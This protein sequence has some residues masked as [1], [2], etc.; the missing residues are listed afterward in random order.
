MGTDKADSRWGVAAWVMALL[1]VMAP[2]AL[3]QTP[4]RILILSDTRDHDKV[5]ETVS[6]VIDRP[7]SFILA[8]GDM[9]PLAK[10]RAALDRFFGPEI[11]WYPVIGN[12]EVGDKG[13][14]RYL[15]DFYPKHLAGK[16]NP[17]PPGT[18]KTTYSFDFANVHVALINVYWNGKARPG[19][20]TRADGDVVPALRKWLEADLRKS[21]QPWKL[22]MAH[23]PAFPQDDRDWK[24]S[25]H[26]TSSLNRHK[27]NRDAFWKVL[28]ETHTTR[29]DLRPHPPLQPNPARG[30]QRLADRRRPDPRRL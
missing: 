9:D 18:E 7:I 8:P 3:A 6:K 16:V 29:A 28:E 23:E 26:E 10:A 25:R 11:P 20:E 1:V 2:R 15:H 21:R 27:E 17:G 13:S 24:G 12:H 5:F 14:M 4:V 30:E 22:V 19:N